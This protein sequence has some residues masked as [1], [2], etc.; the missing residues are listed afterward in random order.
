MDD[1]DL[2]PTGSQDQINQPLSVPLKIYKQNEVQVTTEETSTEGGHHAPALASPS[3]LGSH[4]NEDRTYD[5]QESSGTPDIGIITTVS[6]G[7]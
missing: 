4:E 3:R 5:G 6:R 2:S 7:L 1:L